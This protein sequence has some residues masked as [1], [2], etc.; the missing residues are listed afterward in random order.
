MSE[1]KTTTTFGIDLGTTYSCISYM[2]DGHPTVCP[3]KEG[4]QTTP[5]VVRMLP[6][7]D[8]P[9]VGKTAKDS[10][11]MYP[12]DTIQFVKS[13]IGK[14]A[15]FEIGV[16]DDKRIVSPID[17]SAEI[18]KKLA[19]DASE[20]T[21]M[22]VKDV[23]ITVPA[24]FGTNEKAA[25]KEA[26]EKAGLN[27]VSIVEEPTAAAFYYVFEKSDADA[28][29]CVY[30]LG[31]GTFDVTAIEKK[32][33][34]IEVITTEGDHDLG[35]KNWDALFIDYIDE[36]FREATG[37]D[38]DEELESDYYQD[39]Q[40]KCEEA[41]KTITSAGK[42]TVSIR[43][44]RQHSA[45]ITVTREEFDNLT[46]TLLQTSIDLTKKVFEE[47]EKKGKKINKLL[48]VGG[49]SYM[50]QV[51]DAIQK[52]F[53]SL[54]DEI[55]LNEP[56]LSVSKGACIYCA[57]Y[58]SHLVGSD[59]LTDDSKEEE[60]T[61][62]TD[63]ITEVKTNENTGEKILVIDDGKQKRE[64]VIP[65]S[66][67]ETIGDVGFVA[68]KSFG[69]KVIDNGKEIIY[70][71]VLKDTLLPAVNEQTFYTMQN[72]QTDLC[73]KL[74]QSDLRDEM[75]ELDSGVLIGEATI[76]GIPEGKPKGTPVVNRLELSR[77]GII[78]VTASYNG[79]PLNGKLST[80]YAEGVGQQ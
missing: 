6:E 30:D 72:D 34:S 1:T 32:G 63:T 50:P 31:G 68:T 57:W 56:N 16:G 28:T 65:G 8:V 43:L 27:V 53:G 52:E 17:V 66:M 12:D 22:P 61:V 19:N 60:F 5:S 36:K 51:K 58:F 33:T 75:I 39:L 9:V 7:D 70:N 71:L 2:K 15:E 67:G 11:V 40:I 79:S 41:K 14:V 21:N 10:S 47:V 44:D 26:G 48:L 23:V 35:G 42:A 62:G 77:E 73:I 45:N 13:K 69:I 24:Y 54:V 29:V 37:L 20:F 80:N 38:A 46:S 3:N 18:L 4:D 74:F 76:T 55:L 64:L 59:P 78:E 49:S 25:T